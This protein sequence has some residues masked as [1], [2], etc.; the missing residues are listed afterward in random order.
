[1]KF[2]MVATAVLITAFVIGTCG[3]V[4]A[5]NSDY[6]EFD[7]TNP[8]N[9]GGSGA[10]CGTRAGTPSESGGGTF[11]YHV[12]VSNFSGQTAVLR[13]TH[14]D[15]VDFERYQVPGGTSFSLTHEGGKNPTNKAVRFSIENNGRLAGQASVTGTNVFCLSCDA[16]ADGAPACDALIPAGGI[17]QG[18]N[19]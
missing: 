15:G 14:S 7:G 3:P 9:Q 2:A 19:N 4:Q 8:A 18:P 17:G 5:G 1:M 10:L 13:L 12:S 6:A 11:T 16:D